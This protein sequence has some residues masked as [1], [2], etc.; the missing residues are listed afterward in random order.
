[1][2]D[3]YL[4]DRISTFSEDQIEKLF[5]CIVDHKKQ[6]LEFPLD[7]EVMTELKILSGKLR[8]TDDDYELFRHR[9]I[10]DKLWTMLLEKAIKCLRFFDNRE[11]FLESKGTKFPKA[12]GIGALKRYYEQYSE[13]EHVLYGSN[14]YYRDHVVH[15]FRTWIS[16]VDLL[17][18]NGGRFIET[19]S[20]QDKEGPPELKKVEKLSMWTIIALTHD[21]GYPLEKAKSIIDVTQKMVSTFVTNPDVSIDFAFHGVQ[22]YMNDFIVRLMSSKMVKQDG[23]YFA[24]LQPKYYFKFQ[25]SLERNSHGILST[26]IIYKLLTYFL[27][28]DYNINEDYPFNED[29]RRQFYIRR[30]ILRSIA[31]HTCD[32]VYQMYMGSFSFLL[33][34][35]DDTQEWG[36]KYLSELYVKP[37]TEYELKKIDFT[38]AEREG[39]CNRCSIEEQIK[40]GEQPDSNALIKLISRFHKQAL[41]YI[42]IFRDGQDTKN[43]DFSFL[44]TMRIEFQEEAIVLRLEIMTDRASKMKGTIQYGTNDQRKRMLSSAFLESVES[45]LSSKVEDKVLF[46]KN[47]SQIAPDSDDVDNPS[48]WKALDFSVILLG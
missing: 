44:R 13:F 28:S 41:T 29:D 37:N 20:I 5:P 30:E 17:T 45:A 21:L 14:E 12:Y 40:F 10:V 31:S 18:Q 7:M 23:K 9:Q 46:D 2:K 33:R 43:R 42:M 25:K 38:I 3:K 34:I 15:V 36:R 11:P 8:D 1:M 24:R 19:I 47:D 39:E 4:I 35:C 48:K 26:L 22:N 27:E 16:G 32:D 6:G